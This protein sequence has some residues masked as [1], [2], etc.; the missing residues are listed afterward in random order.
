MKIKLL[1]NPPPKNVPAATVTRELFKIIV[2][3]VTCGN[4]CKYGEECLTR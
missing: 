4:F 2:K 1:E 3:S